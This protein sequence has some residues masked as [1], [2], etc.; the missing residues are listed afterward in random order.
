M[1]Q[2]K[3]SEVAEYSALPPQGSKCLCGEDARATVV[4]Q[5][6]VEECGECHTQVVKTHEVRLC[7]VHN[8]LRMQGAI[9][10]KVL[11][12]ASMMHASGALKALPPEERDSTLA[13]VF[14]PGDGE[15]VER[16]FA[17][18]ESGVRMLN[19]KERDTATKAL[20]AS[21]KAPTNG[22]DS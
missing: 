13:F 12:L 20:R 9:D 8:D 21:L 4:L 5:T 2:D 14:S 6:G 15:N 19:D 18:D 10:G 3:A 1:A 17:S 16:V 7:D 22:K 11:L